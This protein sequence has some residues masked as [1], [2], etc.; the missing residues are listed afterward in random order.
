MHVFTEN[1]SAIGYFQAE[2]L[3]RFLAGSIPSRALT[4]AAQSQET[5]LSVT[6]LR[7]KTR[8]EAVG[9]TRVITLVTEESALFLHGWTSLETE[10]ISPQTLLR[11]EAENGRFGPQ[12][13]RVPARDASGQSVLEVDPRGAVNTSPEVAIDFTVEESGDYDLLLAAQGVAVNGKTDTSFVW[14]LD[15]GPPQSWSELPPVVAGGEAAKV[16]LLTTVHLT[17]GSHRLSLAPPSS[18]PRPPIALQ[19]DA[20]ALRPAARV[21]SALPT[22]KD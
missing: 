15:D 21:A 2:P 4:L 17:A 9:K 7:G 13:R 18:A 22:K 10:P 1:G 12:W 11:F 14:S 5:P 20:L 8:E 3:A 19:L 16:R 6:N